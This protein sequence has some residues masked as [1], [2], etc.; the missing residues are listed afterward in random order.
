MED[1]YDHL[2]LRVKENAANA[3]KINQVRFD[4]AGQVIDDLE[5]DHHDHDE[6]NDTSGHS[7]ARSM[8]LV[9]CMAMR[10]I[11]F[12]KGKKG[13]KGKG[14]LDEAEESGDDEEDG[15]TTLNQDDATASVNPSLSIGDTSRTS[16]THE[17]EEDSLA[18]D[19][20]D[21]V[22]WKCD[23]CHTKNL[24]S[25]N[26]DGGTDHCTLCGTSRPDVQ[27]GH[28][29]GD[30][31]GVTDME[32][33]RVQA[34]LKK[35]GNVEGSHKHDPNVHYDP[36]DPNAP[37][38]ALRANEHAEHKKN[39]LDSEA[40]E[41]DIEA[42][43]STESTSD[44]DL[45]GDEET[46]M[47]KFVAMKLEE[48]KRE[49]KLARQAA[50]EQR[51]REREEKKK[52]KAGMM[53][54]DEFS[55]EE[56]ADPNKEDEEKEND[57]DLD[58]GSPKADKRKLLQGL[59]LLTNDQLEK[60]KASE[61]RDA[62]LDEELAEE[63]EENR[64]SLEDGGDAAVL[65]ESEDQKQHRLTELEQYALKMREMLGKK[66]LHIGLKAQRIVEW[67]EELFGRTWLFA[68]HLAL[69]IEV[70]RGIGHKK[71][72]RYFGT[73]RTDLF[74]ALFHRVIDIHNIEIV[75]KVM[76]PFEVACLYGR[77]GWLH[78]WNPCK[79]EGAWEL[80]L[81]RPEERLV[82]KMLCELATVEP[83]DN[84]AEQ[85]FQWQRDSEGMPGW[86]LTT[87]WLTEEGMPCRGVL[88]LNYYSGAG[89]GLKGCSPH[90][91]F[92]KS[93][94]HLVLIEEHEIVEEGFRDRPPTNLVGDAYV[95][96]NSGRWKQYLGAIVDLTR[97]R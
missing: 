60:Q 65:E 29:I 59:N 78:L 83:G 4:D 44:D 77:I 21:P 79:P 49:M 13:K 30:V 38:L 14:E 26:K 16:V 72:T 36:D 96:N 88:T 43:T 27:H 69:I 76:S 6:N 66:G 93:L 37:I 90:V 56:Y 19:S 68:R 73:Y 18:G 58:V 9:Q 75:L 35:R 64:K 8:S 54:H 84:W 53:L 42:S 89:K 94:L 24:G 10:G 86:E 95:Y 97:T 50:R 63:K 70:V 17:G 41:S 1:F 25:E 61:E 34:A 71:Q 7:L 92:R 15:S 39:E 47:L 91:P 62:A 28:G 85:Y 57:D 22:M 45:D 87:P 55:D 3:I 32:T 52:K 23:K 11:D 31:S 33:K 12:K 81:T 48:K 46:D 67:L 74:V 51:R 20:V 5:E 40:E 82:A 80:S 2:H